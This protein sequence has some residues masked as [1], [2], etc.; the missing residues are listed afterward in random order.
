MIIEIEKLV[1]DPR[2][3]A[4]AL[5]LSDTD[6]Y[7]KHLDEMPPIKISE[8]FHVKDGHKRVATAIRLGRTT[9]RAEVV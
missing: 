2:T 8:D 5:L 7:N 1:L 3:F 4:E 9:V 6:N